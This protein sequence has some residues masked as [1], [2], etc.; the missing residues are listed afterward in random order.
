M[1]VVVLVSLGRLLL[2][3]DGDAIVQHP[4]K[5]SLEFVLVRLATGRGDFREGARAQRQHVMRR[6]VLQDRVESPPAG[7]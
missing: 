2:L 4:Q 7:P 3:P 6:G 1:H 5:L